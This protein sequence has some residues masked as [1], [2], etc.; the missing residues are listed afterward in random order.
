[1]TLKS[2]AIA[3]L[4][5]AAIAGAGH[6]ATFQWSY[7]DL[8]GAPVSASG[9]LD[10]TSVGGGA[11][12]VTSIS[13]LRNGAAITGLA[14]YAIPS[15]LVYSGSPSLDYGGLAFL[16]GGA[17]FN[18]YYD[19]STTDPY[20]CGAVGYCEIG[21]GVDGTDGLAGPDPIHQINFTLTSVPEPSTWAL[22]ILGVG[23]VGLMLRRG[24]KSVAP[25]A[26]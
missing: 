21:P 4:G 17:A 24:R 6:A 14:N 5:M 1:M 12:Q 8:S 13:G 16:A 10:A 25:Q 2:I 3:A 19:T 7:S 15:Q 11:F 26:A 20:S 22:S 9:I 23:A 18:V